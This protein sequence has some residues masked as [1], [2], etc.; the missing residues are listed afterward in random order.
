MFSNHSDEALVRIAEQLH[1]PWIVKSTTTPHQ[2][3]QYIEGWLG[4]FADVKEAS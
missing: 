4:V 1:A 2:L 3:N